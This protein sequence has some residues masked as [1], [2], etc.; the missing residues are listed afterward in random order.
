MPE[1]ALRRFRYGDERPL[2]ELANHRA[3]WINLADTFPH[4]YTLESA[5]EWVKFA[6]Q[7]LPVTN[8]AVT[9]DDQLAG[10]AGVKL[11][12]G[13]NRYTGEVGY[14]LGQPFWGQGIGTEVLA[15]LTELCFTHLGLLRTQAR[16]FHYNPASM[17]VLE[18]NGYRLEAVLRQAACKA[19]Q[20]VDEHLYALLKS[21][22]LAARRA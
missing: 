20:M 22:W 3:V 5:V 13:I 2:A 17:R 16:V 15:Q 1:I 7:A 18:K 6:S 8:L 11:M 4:P 14:W 12:D 9:V 19:D 21:E 10:G